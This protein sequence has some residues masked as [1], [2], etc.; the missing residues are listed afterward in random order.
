MTAIEK[1]FRKKYLLSQNDILQSLEGYMEYIEY[2]S[3]N[4]YS[5]ELIKNKL[6]LCE[7]FYEKIEK[8]VLPVLTQFYWHYSYIDS[9]YGMELSIS[10]G[11]ALTL[12]DDGEY[13]SDFTDT[14]IQ[15]I[16]FV[17][18]D[19]VTPEEFARIQEVSVA[20]VKQWLKKGRLRHA[21]YIDGSW[22]IPATSEKPDNRYLP[23]FYT[24][25]LENP[26]YIE[27]FPIISVCDLILIYREDRRYVC[28]LGNT[29]THF[30]EKMYLSKEEVERLEYALIKSGKA[31]IQSPIQF[32][33]NIEKN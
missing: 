18:T 25:D 13:I 9:G 20:T 6:A 32:I 14:N 11:E 33:P 3:D 8:C 23:F 17:E 28:D 29:K 22:L 30:S 5:K 15:R 27:E 4:G 10:D 12:S 19:Y 7:K 26:V 31:H 1:A 16:L 21:K 24:F 2:D